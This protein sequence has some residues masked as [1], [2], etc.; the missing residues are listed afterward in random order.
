MITPA[1]F[2]RQQSAD[3]ASS[4]SWPYRPAS[5]QM[6]QEFLSE[7]GPTL[8]ASSKAHLGYIQPGCVLG[9]QVNQLS[10]AQLTLVVHCM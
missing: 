3:R 1:Q 7:G 6:K 5:R 8:G 2:D 4:F 10:V 9:D